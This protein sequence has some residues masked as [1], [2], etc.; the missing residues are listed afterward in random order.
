MNLTTQSWHPEDLDPELRRAIDALKQGPQDGLPESWIL[1][2]PEYR[3]ASTGD[4]I[5][6]DLSDRRYILT[7]VPKQLSDL[8]REDGLVRSEPVRKFL[9]GEPVEFMALDP[10]ELHELNVEWEAT[11]QMSRRVASGPKESCFI[12]PICP[13]SL[14][15]RYK[16]KSGNRWCKKIVKNNQKETQEMITHIVYV[17]P[18]NT[19]WQKVLKLLA[20][21]NQLRWYSG[22]CPTHLIPEAAVQVL[23]LD[24]AQDRGTLSYN[25]TPVEVYDNTYVIDSLDD[26]QRLTTKHLGA[27]APKYPEHISWSDLRYA[28]ACSDGLQ[29]FEATFG[30]NASVKYEALKRL[31]GERNPTWPDWLDKHFAK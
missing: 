16:W 15:E 31:A 7:Q 24:I 6:S 18:S 25:C 30:L 13:R 8:V 23:H 19:T 11:P 5:F 12:R 26:L 17:K 27:P 14:E 20:R 29:W 10:V 9:R 1:F 2:Y 21:W 28:H 22:G 4:G 3:P